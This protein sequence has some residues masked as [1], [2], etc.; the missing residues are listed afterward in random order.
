MKKVIILAFIGFL[1]ASTLAYTAHQDRPCHP[2]GDIIPCGHA[3]HYA[4]DIIPC[5]HVCVNNW[6]NAIP[7]HPGGDAV[8]CSHALHS[9]GDIV[10]CGHVCY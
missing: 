7:C 9:G 3:M 8:P 6:G 10:P 1:A 2:A 5:G 4:G